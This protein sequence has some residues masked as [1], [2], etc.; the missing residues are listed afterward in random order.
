[1]VSSYKV[2]NPSFGCRAFATSS[3]FAKLAHSRATLALSPHC[4]SR[5][6]RAVR[7]APLAV[8]ARHSLC[9]QSLVK[10]GA[11]RTQAWA[12]HTSK[13]TAFGHAGLAVEIPVWEH[14]TPLPVS[15]RLK[16]QLSMPARFCTSPFASAAQHICRS[17]GSRGRRASVRISPLKQEHVGSRQPPNPSFKRTCLRQAA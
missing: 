17:L 8:S 12:C 9:H 2:V 1:M 7:P 14:F 5:S 6:A 15:Q 4:R 3:C 11:S 10:A 16:P 13:S